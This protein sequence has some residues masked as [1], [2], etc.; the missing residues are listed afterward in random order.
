MAVYVS[1]HGVSVWLSMWC[2]SH[3]AFRTSSPRVRHPNL[4]DHPGL[5]ERWLGWVVPRDVD[6][7]A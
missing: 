1:G 4:G 6:L 3:V 5:E 7:G 2:G